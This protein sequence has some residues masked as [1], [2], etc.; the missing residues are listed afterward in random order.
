[1]ENTMSV[2]IIWNDNT[3]EFF[4]GKTSNILQQM[5]LHYNAGSLEGNFEV[6]KE[7]LVLGDANKY[8]RYYMIDPPLRCADYTFTTS[9]SRGQVFGATI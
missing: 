5:R 7:D 2:Y 9:F 4:V 6:L 1:M 8:V 3:K